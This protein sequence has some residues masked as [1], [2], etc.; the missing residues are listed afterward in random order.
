LEGNDVDPKGALF[1][2]E[3]IELMKSVFDDAAAMLPESKRT[4][5]IKA[6]RASSILACA[7]RGE[8]NPATLKTQAL[9]VVQAHFPSV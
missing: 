9:R 4:S 6:E 8:R 5:S 7:A 3:L 2:P 1:D